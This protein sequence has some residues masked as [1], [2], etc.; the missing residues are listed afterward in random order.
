VLNTVI[1]Q[2]N[3]V[4]ERLLEAEPGRVFDK[5][6]RAY[7]SLRHGYSL[8]SSE[9]MNMLSLVRLGVDLNMFPKEVR[10]TIDRLFMECQP[11]HVQYAAKKPIESGER[12]TF[13]ASLLRSE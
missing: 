7:G 9:A 5:V 4:R 10:P 2:E 12:D 11:G 6:G 13:R 1:E 8:S 3:N